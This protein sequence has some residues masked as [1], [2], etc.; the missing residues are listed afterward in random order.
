MFP[1][2]NPT[3]LENPTPKQPFLTTKKLI[4]ILVSIFVVFVGA[5]TALILLIPQPDDKTDTTESPKAADNES[6]LTLSLTDFFQPNNLIVNGGI[7][8][9]AEQKS[10]PISISNLK[11]KEVESHINSLL[12]ENTTPSIEANFGDVIS[13]QG[14]RWTTNKEG[15]RYEEYHGGFNLRLDT[16]KPIEFTDLFT[17]NTNITN[18]VTE[19]Y[20]AGLLFNLSMK[21]CEAH[22]EQVR[23]TGIGSEE[24]CGDADASLVDVGPDFEEELIKAANHYREN[25]VD[26]FYFST[27]RINF[28]LLGVDCFINMAP[29]HDSIAIYKR[30]KSSDNLY[31]QD[32]E[33]VEMFA[34]ANV[35]AFAVTYNNAARYSQFGFFADNLFVILAGTPCTQEQLGTEY[36]RSSCFVHNDLI[37]RAKAIAAKSPNERFLLHGWQ[38]CSY[39][40]SKTD[41]F[42]SQDEFLD[43]LAESSRMLNAG[44]CG[45]SIANHYEDWSIVFDQSTD[46]LNDTADDTPQDEPTPPPS[47]PTN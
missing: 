19:S 43:V 32:F 41:R 26:Y 31:Q 9:D 44:G 10:S 46:H 14:S 15:V 37:A 13:F 6:H 34:F 2:A 24:F 4:I 16:G 29:I 39:G 21:A 33:L 45:I 28:T 1:S 47:D 7:W 23:K 36:I 5:T 42:T 35:W 3:S 40:L 18:L 25:S 11:N 30:F 38:G 20:R 27:W 22:N 12:S 8:S 17:A